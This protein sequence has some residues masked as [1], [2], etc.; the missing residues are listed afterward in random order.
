MG[1]DHYTST[2]SDKID[3]QANSSA[4]HADTRI[5][6]S[7]SW[8]MENQKKETTLALG[9]SSST[10][11]DYQSF[12]GNI[13]FSAKTKDR[14]G[15]F[16]A[17]FQTYHDQVIL[18]QPVELRTNVMGHDQYGSAARN[19]FSGSLSYSQMNDYN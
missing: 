4:S 14:S 10:E 1:I 12:G 7:L 3:L 2:S 18:I 15:E 11:F 19:T 17:K 5:Y 9:L 16:T 13:S 8:S 6:P